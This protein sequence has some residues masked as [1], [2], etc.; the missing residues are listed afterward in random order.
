M[1]KILIVESPAK[2]KT[3]SKFLG[4]DF[5]VLST[6]GHVKDLPKKEL[7]VTIPEDGEI[8]LTYV[9]L[10]KKE[11]VISD[12]CK[13]ASRADEVYLAPDPDREGELIAWH[14]GEEVAKVMKSPE[15]IHRITFNE[16]T[17]SAITDAIKNPSTVDLNKVAAQQARRVL[18]RWVGYQVSPV[19]WRK[20]QKGLSAGRVQSVALKL[21][22]NREDQ[23]RAFVP[24]E[25][26]SITGIFA[27]AN[28]ELMTATLSTIGRKKAELASQEEITKLLPKLNDESYAISKIKDS[29]R[30]K[31]A[32]APFMT[33]TLQ[34]AAYNQLGFSVQKTMSLAQRLYEGVPLQDKNTP[35]ALITYMRT[36]S[37]RIAKTALDQARKCINKLFGKEYLPTKSLTYAKEKAQDAHE[38]IR[39]IDV[40]L[41]PE[42]I[43]NYIETDL[44]K[45]YQLIW[46]R[47]IACQ[48]KPAEYA[49]RSVT[50][51]G[52]TYTFK[53]TGSTLLFDGFLKAYSAQ[54]SENEE[55][56]K[57]SKI[58]A[59]I[60]EQMALNL[61]KIEPKQHFTQAPPRYTEASLVKELEKE[62]IGRPSTYATIL[63]TIQLRSYTELDKRK[64]F[65]PTELGFAVTKLLDANLPK[66]MNVAFTAHMEEDL[67]KIAQGELKRDSLLHEFYGDFSKALEKFAGESVERPMEPTTIT[68]PECKQH[69]L[70]IRFG[71]AG[72]FIGCPGYPECT[73]S[74]P[75]KR[76]EDGTI[77]LI[78]RKEPELLEETCP[79]CN[80]P[81]Q[82]R[83]GRFGEFT[84]CSGY[85]ECKYI[86]QQTTKFMCPG[87]QKAPLARRSWRGK[88]FWSCQ[89]YPTC[90]FSISGDIQE[91]VCPQCASPYLLKYEKDGIKKL[92]CPNRECGFTKI[93]DIQE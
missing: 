84:S 60:Q 73:F 5:K 93:E 77:T 48:M 55:E 41:T 70:V 4:K 22:C 40:M 37:L 92:T 57:N 62:R 67:D 72:A 81:L 51:T 59:N 66:I 64:R 45:L 79:Q 15:N 16:I 14:I 65:V 56:E 31:K 27:T 17:Q 68:C 30:Q 33:S 54:E 23:I 7:G 78:E 46:K 88:V 52:G 90:K 83:M 32:A 3:I 87:C 25:Y 2:T 86:K 1:K 82:K 89:S 9:P 43:E 35:V 28:N 50:I 18:D 63:K 91:E 34:Q 19:L 39:P 76:E 26:W 29:K 8:Q 47:F 49:Q 6:M 13:E 38:A 21:I 85:P 74:S 10:E 11:R 75:F 58:P 36:D 42:T 53:A 80:K 24:E 71:R 12:I 61:N 20:L 69:K 44:F